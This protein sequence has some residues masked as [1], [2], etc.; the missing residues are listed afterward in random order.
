MPQLKYKDVRPDF[1][2]RLADVQAHRYPVAILL[3][4]VQD[5]HNIAMIFRLCDAARIEHLYIYG[6]TGFGL[7]KKVSSVTRSTENYVNYT[8]LDDLNSVEQLKS[9]YTFTGLDWTN[10]SIDY[11][12]FTPNKNTLLIAGNE[13]RGISDELQ[14]LCDNFIHLPMYGIIT[15]MN[16]A[17]AT[18]IAAYE[19]IKHFPNE[20][21]TIK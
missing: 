16:V 21:I 10:E 12:S 20:K 3:D 8:L 2:K 18:S 1:D 7:D 9:K 6:E 13:Q 11:Q 4:R 19:L 17:C 14:L 15:S 5:K